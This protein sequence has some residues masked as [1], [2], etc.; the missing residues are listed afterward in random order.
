MS[1]KLSSKLSSLNLGGAGVNT[2]GSNEEIELPLKSKTSS[3]CKPENIPEGKTVSLLWDSI[4]VWREAETPRNCSVFIL[5]IS[6]PEQE[7]H[8]KLNTDIKC[9]CMYCTT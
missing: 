2:A 7:K 8:I 3:D 5:D 6:F 1:N 4:N 9:I